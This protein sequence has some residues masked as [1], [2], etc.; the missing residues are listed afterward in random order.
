MPRLETALGIAY[1]PPLDYRGVAQLVEY[2]S[3]K[4]GVVGSSPSAPASRLIQI[5]TH[6]KPNASSLSRLSP[7]AQR[8]SH[9]TD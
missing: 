5:A 6:A 8:R 4:P 9:G 2:R 7:P 3:P 1:W